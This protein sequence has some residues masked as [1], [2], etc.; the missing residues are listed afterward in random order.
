MFFWL[1]ACYSKLSLC[2]AVSFELADLQS[3]FM[4]FWNY[5]ASLICLPLKFSVSF[6]TDSRCVISCSSLKVISSF[7]DDIDFLC[8]YNLFLLL[9][10]L[11]CKC[12]R[13]KIGDSDLIGL[14]SD[15]L[16]TELFVGPVSSCAWLPLLWNHH[17]IRVMGRGSS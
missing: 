13:H 14:H 7:G 6:E 17:P 3:S 12:S 16:H 5:E 10:K 15:A 9:G 2:L 11:H 4:L 8:S 1:Q